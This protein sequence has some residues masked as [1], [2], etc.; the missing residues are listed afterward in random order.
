MTQQLD[1]AGTQSSRTPRG[2]ENA[3]SV[4]SFWSPVALAVDWIGDKL[5]VADAMGQ[6][7]DIFEFDGMS[8]VIVLSQNI[9]TPYDIA[10]DPTQ[11]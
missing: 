2:A 1:L 6:K 10:L 7:I 3:I 9:S 8:H 11:G 5:Y 4:V